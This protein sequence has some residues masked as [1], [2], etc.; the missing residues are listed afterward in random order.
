MLDVAGLRESLAMFLTELQQV[1]A[2]L[3][4]TNRKLEQVVDLLKILAEMEAGESETGDYTVTVS[5]DDWA[6]IVQSWEEE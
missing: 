6:A 4:E 2:Q 1:N 3:A 5:P